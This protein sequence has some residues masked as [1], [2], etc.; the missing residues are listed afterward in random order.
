MNS[1][2]SVSPAR[3]GVATHGTKLGADLRSALRSLG[4]NPTHIRLAMEHIED[5]GTARGSDAIDTED[6]E[7]LDSMIRTATEFH[8]F[9]DASGV[10]GGLGLRWSVDH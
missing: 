6:V 10:A 7:T 8:E 5:N 2:P 1:L 4:Y 3:H 9:A